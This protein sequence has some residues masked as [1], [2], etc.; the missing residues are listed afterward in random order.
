LA[1]PENI[2]PGW[3]GLPLTNALA[4][5]EPLSVTNEKKF[6]KFEVNLEKTYKYHTISFL[7]TFAFNAL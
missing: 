6:S 7:F 5:L 4:Y 2:R 1:L 3:K